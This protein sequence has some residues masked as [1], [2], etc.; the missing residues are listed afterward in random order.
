MAT[1]SFGLDKNWGAVAATAKDAPRATGRIPDLIK[2]KFTMIV[3][4]ITESKL[5]CVCKFA[6]YIHLCSVCLWQS[7]ISSGTN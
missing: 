5:I 4:K 2:L 3:K 6:Q 7:F 1:I